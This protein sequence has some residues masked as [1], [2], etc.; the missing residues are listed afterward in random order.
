MQN[1]EGSGTPIL[2]IGRTALKG[3]IRNNKLEVQEFM[4]N[5]APNNN[6]LLEN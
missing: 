2:Y 3:Q 5:V 6:V 4:F 1:L